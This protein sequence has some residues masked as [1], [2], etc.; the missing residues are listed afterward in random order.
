MRV[1]HAF[2]PFVFLA[3]ACVCVFAPENVLFVRRE[4]CMPLVLFVDYFKMF[5]VLSSMTTTVVVR[6]T[7]ALHILSFD[8]VSAATRSSALLS[9]IA[10]PTVA[11]GHLECISCF[12]CALLSEP[13][14]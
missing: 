4:V 5:T 13:L 10:A 8:C 7:T 9:R 12:C 6:V 14:A 11:K 1:C 2:G 3:A